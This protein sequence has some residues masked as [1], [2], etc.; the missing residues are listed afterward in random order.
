MCLQPK[1]GQ[2]MRETWEVYKIFVE[3]SEL[4]LPRR[5]FGNRNTFNLKNIDTN[6]GNGIIYLGEGA[7]ILK[8]VVNIGAS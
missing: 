8:E 2:I 7:H 3:N 4:H 6:A 1:N 5:S